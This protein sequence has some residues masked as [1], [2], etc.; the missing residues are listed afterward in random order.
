MISRS[1]V[2]AGFLLASSLT[3]APAILAD[4]AEQRLPV[5]LAAGATFPVVLSRALDAKHSKPGDAVVAKLTQRVPLGDGLYLP[6]AAEL[7]GTV[8][9]SP[10]DTLTIEFTLLRLHTTTQPIQVKLVAGAS[11]L[12]LES[13]REPLGGPTHSTSDWT[14][15][16]I[17]GDEIYG[18]N[19]ATKVYDRYSRQVGLADGTGVYAPPLAPGMPER[20][21]GPFS[22]TA[23]G[24]YDLPGLRIASPGSTGGPIVFG[25]TGAKWQLHAQTGLLLQ[26]IVP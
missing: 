25:L 16:Q 13:T 24:L 14:T 23:S 20:A 6:D 22:T 11:W 9:A 2:A 4:K 19:V 8:L 5:P 7:V 3:L 17:G 12:D 21:M 10:A 18:A 26:V 1:R 15:K